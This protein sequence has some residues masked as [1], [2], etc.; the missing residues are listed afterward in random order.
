M[1]FTVT[2]FIIIF[3]FLNSFGQSN[4]ELNSS[5]EKLIQK[6]NVTGLSVCLTMDNEIVYKKSY[7]YANLKYGN[8][9][10]D[11]TFFRI[12]S[13]SKT[14]T[15]TA[16]FQLYEQG[17]LSLDADISHYLGYKVRNPKYP[18]NI[19]TIRMLANHVSSLNDG[20]GYDGFLSATYSAQIPD[21]KE[22]LLPDGAYYTKDT[23]QNYKPGGGYVY[24]NSGYG[25]LGTIVEKVSGERFD[26]Y[27]KNHIFTPL[28]MKSSFNVDDVDIKN[29]AVL[30][31]DTIPQYDNY[32]LKKAPRDLSRYVIGTNAAAFSPQGGL[33]TSACDLA[34]FLLAH[35]NK[36]YYNGA[37]ILNDTTALILEGK[38]FPLKGLGNPVKNRGVSMHYTQSLLKGNVLIGHAGGAYGLVSGMYFDKYRRIG[39]I[40][41]AN[42]GEYGADDGYSQFEKELSAVL[43]NY[44]RP[45]LNIEND[46]FVDMDL[47]QALERVER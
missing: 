9:V 5:I 29:L 46:I 10:N 11:S 14:I 25:L 22:L 42:G 38:V 17:L 4:S 23:W 39:I 21:I 13:V 41:M 6:Y 47:L 19:I 33:R 30:Y 18:D 16:I 28:N 3:A 7:G 40:F 44:L 15:G 34:K 27:C 12:A 36:G 26:R 32:G 8:K 2:C 24:C 37:K 31:R 1:R 43:Y 45:M 20:M 35:I